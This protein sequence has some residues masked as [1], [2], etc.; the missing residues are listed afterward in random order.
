MQEDIFMKPPR[1]NNIIDRKRYMLRYP[2]PTAVKHG[3]VD[4]DFDKIDV[5]YEDT[6]L[7]ALCQREDLTVRRLVEYFKSHPKNHACAVDMNHSRVPLHYLCMHKKLN[8]EMLD[9]YFNHTEGYGC[10]AAEQVDEYGERTPLDY[11]LDN[12]AKL[13]VTMWESCIRFFQSIVTG[14]TQPLL[15]P[16]LR[17]TTQRKHQV[18]I[19]RNKKRGTMFSDP[20]KNWSPC[21]RTFCG[22][23][24]DV[25]I[26]VLGDSR[27]KSIDLSQL[28]DSSK[29]PNYTFPKSN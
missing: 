3:E 15:G 22:L 7:H 18:T 4:H 29:A 2:T 5:L 21:V 16:Y 11:L 26:R 1:K 9:V 10:R 28:H 12:K 27:E 19:H 6:D 23:P 25:S 20:S 8:V 13:R 24:G 17:D 14:S